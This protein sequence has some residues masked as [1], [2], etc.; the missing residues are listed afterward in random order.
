MKL[1]K[2]TAA[3]KFVRRIKKGNSLT[4]IKYS[5]MIGANTI[6]NVAAEMEIPCLASGSLG[7]YVEKN[8]SPIHILRRD[9]TTAITIP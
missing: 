9:S 1:E 3:G 4:R 8:C 2:R 7:R 5:S 6:E